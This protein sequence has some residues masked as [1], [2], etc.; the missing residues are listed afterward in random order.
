MYICS[1]CICIT[2]IHIFVWLLV[3]Y[4]IS[5]E[6]I[7]GCRVIIA[8][9]WPSSTHDIVCVYVCGYDSK[10]CIL[11]PWIWNFHLIT[12]IFYLVCNTYETQI[13]ENYV[14]KNDEN[15]TVE[16]WFQTKRWTKRCD[17]VSVRDKETQS[18]K[19]IYRQS[20][21]FLRIKSISS[22]EMWHLKM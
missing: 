4:I 8:K 22:F 11:I 1:A 15:W 16:V 20:Q 6:G 21:A 3:Q 18:V 7:Y 14:P 10:L 9:L 2:R 5:L 13:R 19:E 12:R 17:V